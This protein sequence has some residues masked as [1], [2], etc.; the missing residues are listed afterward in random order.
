M[1]IYCKLC[2]LPITSGLALTTPE[3]EQVMEL[4]A[5]HLVAKHKSA[6]VELKQEV[7]MLYPLFASYLLIT[8]YVRVPP[9]A[10]ELLKAMEDGAQ[11]IANLLA[12]SAKPAA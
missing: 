1:T 9:T 10:S 6:A 12:E 2:N 5:R 4:M 3:S 11:A 8:R 7:D